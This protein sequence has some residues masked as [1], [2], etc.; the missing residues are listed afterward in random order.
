MRSSSAPSGK[1]T[2][3]SICAVAWSP[4][5]TSA[6]RGWARKF[7][8]LR[9]DSSVSKMISSRSLT[10]MPTTAACGAPA[11]ETEASTASLCWRRKPINSSRCMPALV[12]RRR[13]RVTLL[14]GAQAPRKD[15][16]MGILLTWLVMSAAFWLTAQIVPGFKVQGFGGAVVVAAVF[17]IINWLIGWLLFVV[18][19]VASLG[20]GF[21]LAFLT[22]WLVNA[23]LL[24]LTDAVSSNLTIRDF[25]TALLGALVLSLLSTL[26]QWLVRF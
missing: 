8:Y 13:F 18:I 4:P 7:R 10:A 5:T 26:G 24:K 21:L 1:S 2:T 16:M 12:S 9:V 14:R 20:I 23:I 19:G 6:M 15:E 11:A 3:P 25:P 22:R 17:G